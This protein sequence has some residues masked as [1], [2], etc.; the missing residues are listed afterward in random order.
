M[1]DRDP[2]GRPADKG[3]GNTDGAGGYAER[4]PGRGDAPGRGRGDSATPQTE[5][6]REGSDRS[7]WRKD[8]KDAAS[9]RFEDGDDGDGA[10][11]G[12]DA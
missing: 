1:R 8:D 10:P 11:A 4:G 9:D 7:R 2:R 6:E 3:S 5:A 12:G